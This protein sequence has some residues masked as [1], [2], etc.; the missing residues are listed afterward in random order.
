MRI[1]FS[2]LLLIFISVVHADPT[3]FPT[4]LMTSVFGELPL[5]V[6]GRIAGCLDQRTFLALTAASKRCEEL[7]LSHTAIMETRKASRGFNIYQGYDQFKMCNR[8]LKSDSLVI[9]FSSR[10]EFFGFFTG[11]R[12][13]EFFKNEFFI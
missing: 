3:P 6:L 2:S 5:E 10:Y 8:K 12:C 13:Q 1:T 7:F 4:P 11:P 9:L